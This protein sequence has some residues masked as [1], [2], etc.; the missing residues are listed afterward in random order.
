VTTGAAKAAGPPDRALAQALALAAGLRPTGAVDRG[1][2]RD[3]TYALDLTGVEVPVVMRVVEHATRRVVEDLRTDAPGAVGV[4]VAARA[5]PDAA[6]AGHVLAGDDLAEAVRRTGLVEWRSGDPAPD[7]EAYLWAARRDRDLRESD[8]IGLRWLPV[9]ARDALPVGLPAGAGPAHAWFERLTFRVLT[10]AFMLRGRRL[11][12]DVPGQAEPDGLLL[13]PGE[14][15]LAVY[16]CKATGDDW[17]ADRATER[18]LTEYAAKTWR[19]EQQMLP[20]S[21]VLVVSSG[22]QAAAGRKH[23]MRARHERLKKA[24]GAD[25]VY[26]TARHLATAGLDLCRRPAGEEIARFVNWTAVFAEGVVTSAGLAAAI[27]A[28]ATRHAVAWTVA[29]AS[30]TGGGP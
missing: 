30:G 12:A 16:D 21:H 3:L 14:A 8:P 18:Q 29:A 23:P 27:D 28:A 5:D 4:V 25:L 26:V 6:T 13:M 9:L 17:L 7:S 20:V 10:R 24:T 2:A 22:F 1:P 15:A 11:G 19:W